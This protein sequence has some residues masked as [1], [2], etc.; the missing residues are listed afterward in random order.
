MK[1]IVSIGERAILSR[2]ELDRLLGLDLGLGL[3]D[4]GH[5]LPGCHGNILTVRLL[6]PAELVV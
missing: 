4:T 2:V 5:V 3:S 1:Q 6:S